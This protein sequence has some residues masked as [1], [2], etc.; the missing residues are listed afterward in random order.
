[1]MR[2]TTNNKKLNIIVSDDDADE[3]TEPT[4]EA[5]SLEEAQVPPL[6]VKT[7]NQKIRPTANNTRKPIKHAI[8]KL[9]WAKYIGMRRG[10]GWC[11]CCRSTEI[12]MFEFEAGHVVAYK[13]GGKDTIDNLRPICRS[14]NASMGTQ[15]MIAFQSEH[16]LGPTRFQATVES[17]ISAI[18]WLFGYS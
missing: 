4:T 18:G 13:N 15:N 14:C 16:N 6:L 8:R 1:M 7:A 17:A 5:S 2:K 11:W 12:N 3:N 10:T 9:V